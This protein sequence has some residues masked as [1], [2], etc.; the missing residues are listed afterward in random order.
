M[1]ARGCR[2]WV[3]RLPHTQVR[4][5][6]GTIGLGSDPMDRRFGARIF[7]AGDGGHSDYLKDGSPAL[8]NITRIVTGH[9]PAEVS[10][11]S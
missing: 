3:S 6:F 7:A 9:A 1:T 5:P 11:A 4:L 8:A 2:D 10:R